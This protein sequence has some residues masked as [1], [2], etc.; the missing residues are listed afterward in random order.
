MNVLMIAIL[1]TAQNVYVDHHVEPVRKEQCEATAP[2]RARIVML[3][4]VEHHV[5][6]VC[7]TIEY[8]A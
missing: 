3:N 5:V 8:P 4:G 7:K 2:G 6:V 1:L